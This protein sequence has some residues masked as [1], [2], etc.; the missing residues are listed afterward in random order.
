MKKVNLTA[1]ESERTICYAQ[2]HFVDIGALDRV[3]LRQVRCILFYLRNIKSNDAKVK[4]L[5]HVE[6]ISQIRLYVFFIHF[7]ELQL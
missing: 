2:C 4:H 7:V 1:S 3:V 6:N 5:K